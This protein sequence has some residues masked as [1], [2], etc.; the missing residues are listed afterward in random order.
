LRKRRTLAADGFS[1]AS[2]ALRTCAR[3]HRLSEANVGIILYRI[4]GNLRMELEEKHERI[5]S[6]K[7]EEVMVLVKS[8]REENTVQGV[9]ATECIGA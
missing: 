7:K 5:F 1:S 2:S 3:L 9:P 8:M 4:L 6:E